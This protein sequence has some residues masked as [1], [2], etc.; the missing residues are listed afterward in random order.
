V[1]AADGPRRIYFFNPFD[2]NAFDDAERIDSTIE[3]SFD[4]CLTDFR[5]VRTAL[6]A[7]RA[8]TI[9]VTY[10]GF[11]GPLPS[12]YELLSAEPIGSDLLCFWRKTYRSSWSRLRAAEGSA[13]L[14]QTNRSLT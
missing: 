13:D 10:H 14:S 11:G 7:A 9:V 5:R 8:G 4:R 3:L 1:A 2:E 6:L 12:G